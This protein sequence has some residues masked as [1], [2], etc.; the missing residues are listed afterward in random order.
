MSEERRRH[1][2]CSKLKDSSVIRRNKL[3]REY[4]GGMCGDLLCWIYRKFVTRFS[5][6]K[7]FPGLPGPAGGWASTRQ[8]SGGR[9]ETGGGRQEVS[10]QLAFPKTCLVT[11][12]YVSIL[13][14][15]TLMWKVCLFVCF[16]LLSIKNYVSQNFSA[17]KLLM[18]IKHS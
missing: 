6:A 16:L 13:Y 7:E 1:Y 14:H 5:D 11:A 10:E 8:F 9:C 2:E 15:L 3:E 4:R 17:G 18:K 12:W